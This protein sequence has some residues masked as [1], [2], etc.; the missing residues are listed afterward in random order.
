MPPSSGLE[1]SLK[2]NSIFRRADIWLPPLLLLA[3]V[4]L[5]AAY[6]YE[7]ASLINFDIPVGPDIG[8]YDQRAREILAGRILPAVP[9]IHAPLYPLF[10]GT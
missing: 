8:E 9:D 1:I 6:L 4:L 10:L 5:R 3:G 2:K 7:Y